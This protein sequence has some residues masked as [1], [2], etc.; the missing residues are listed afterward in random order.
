MRAYF[1]SSALIA[2]FVEE[3]AHHARAAESLV[4]ATDGFTCQHTLAEVFG[5]LTG[6]R[7]GLQLSPMEA[8]QMI[9][10]NVVGKLDVLPLTVNDYMTALK[11]SQGVG[12]RGGAVFDMLHLQAARRGRAGRIYTINVRHFQ[13]LAPDL[14]NII[15]LP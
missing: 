8:T 5:T 4:D 2:A 9:N 13:M 1:D 3:E 6:G 12:A 14:R 15:A 10:A 11:E 7:L